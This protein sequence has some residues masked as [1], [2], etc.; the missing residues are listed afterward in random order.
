MELIKKMYWCGKK[1]H[2]GQVIYQVGIS[3]ATGKRWHRVSGSNSSVALV[4]KLFV[5]GAS[6]LN[7][8]GYGD[9]QNF[10]ENHEFVDLIAKISADKG[11]SFDFADNAK[12]KESGFALDGVLVNGFVNEN[13]VTI[14]IQSAK[15]LNRVVGHE[16]THVLEGTE[17]YNAL[18]SAV[19]EYA[20]GKKEYDSR[21]KELTELYKGKN[22]N[23]E[24]ELVADL[25]GDYLFTDADFIKHL[26]TEHRNL[27]QK[28]Y[29]EIKYLCKVVTAGSKEAR[30]LEKAKKAFADAYRAETKNPT[31]DGGVRYSIVNL[32]TG[33]SYVQASRQVIH[34]NSVAEWRSQISEFFNRA[35]KNGPIE[36]ET[37]EGDILTIS[38]NTAE[39]ARSKTATENGVSR[40]LTDK[41]FLV[42]LHAEAHIDELAE[43]SHKNKRPP[44]PDGKNHSFAKDGFTYRT[45][46]FQDFDGSYYRITL[47]VGENNGISTVYNV[48]KIKAD[49]IPDGKIISTIGSKADMSSTK[50]SISGT[51]ENVNNKNSSSNIAPPVGTDVHGRDIAAHPDDW[52]PIRKDI[53]QRAVRPKQLEE[54]GI[55]EQLRNNQDALNAMEPA[56]EIQ[57]P[58][59]YMQMDIAGKKKWVVEK[60]QQ[61][62]YKVTRKGLGII[63]FAKKR[64]KSAFNYFDEGSVEETAFEALPYVLENGIEISA[65]S[66]H[67]GRT[68]GT[69]TIAAPITINGKRGNMAVVVKQTTGNYYKVHR[70]LT[71][72]GSVFVLP[73]TTKEAEST[74]TGESP[75][76]GSLATSKDS[77]SNNIIS[78]SGAVVNPE[79]STGAA[80]SGF[81]PV[82]HLQYE[83]GSLPE[84]EK[85][86]REDSLPKST[87]GKDKVSLTGRTVKGADATPDALVDLLDK[88]VVE[89]GLSYIPLSNDA[90]VQKAYDRIK[91]LGWKEALEDWRAD[92][93]AGK[94]SAELS[95]TGA[96]LLNN[97]ANAGDRAVWLDVLHEYQR[98]G[99][100]AAQ[101][102]QALRILK[103]LAPEDK[104]YMI[105]KS[106]D[107]M[108][109]DSGYDVEVDEELLNE[110][111]EAET[112]AERDEV[113]DAIMQNVADQIPS[114]F[115]EK[116]TALRY[117]NMLGNLRTQVRN[118]AGNLSMKGVRSIHNTIATGLEAIADTV[119]GGK[120]GRTR[121]VTVSKEQ[122]VAAKNDFEKL[123]SVILD[124]GK[125]SDSVDVSTEFAKGVQEKRRMFK[126]KPLEGYRKATNWAMEQGDLIFARDAYVRALA[127]YLKA[128]GI[129]ET[130]YSRIDTKVLE[131][132]RLFAIKEAQ[133]ATFRDTNWLS[134][135]ISKAGRGKGKPA[136]V[137]TISEGIMPFR[138][139]PANVLIRAEEYSP[140]G[141]VNS[142]YYSVKAMQKESDVTAT[143]VINSWAKS[144][145]GTGLFALGML[146]QSLGCLVGGA[147]DDESKDKFDSMNGWQNYAIVL[148]DGTN[149]TIDFLTPTAMPMATVL[150]PFERR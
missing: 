80:P 20:K 115:M 137:R 30:Q 35:L 108:N 28:I 78:K 92:V 40:E 105:H 76:N 112:D 109:K 117:V 82:S 83:Y 44:V 53:P 79:D 26:S 77:A 16:I 145:T 38:K 96:L 114:T 103:T 148:P 84:G 111:D 147:D 41:E 33:K 102:V 49:D 25:V 134:G 138:K 8:G 93:R 100:S 27:A 142:V 75:K 101:A 85:P 70:I 4:E 95:A 61:T 5:N 66:Q 104:L 123:K 34:G 56:A 98:M 1:L 89:G 107:Q 63:E 59:G 99:T 131:D 6:A 90:T 22:A 132:A 146:L 10:N 21:L 11:I 9:A 113:L 127:G 17:L 58:E 87:N 55:R 91:E 64:L 12:L 67:K 81:D 97:A 129:T 50:L 118:V 136:I 3:E 46:Y 88:T 19:T 32:D 51:S 52:I 62:G 72:D 37:I 43:I 65:H 69:I 149:L 57:V 2:I 128:N 39:K 36:I 48:G 18:Q 13:G 110:W 86:V 133:E 15:A 139:T 120:T 74:P 94:V 7:Y 106:V 71:P 150:F 47:S 125:Y 54:S 130:D 60:L 121:A 42:K 14:N 135:W 143:Q 122:K 119:S 124:G 126:F 68:Y 140:L 116:F 144:L 73:E 31:K 45:V 23:V 29:D 24:Q 141:I